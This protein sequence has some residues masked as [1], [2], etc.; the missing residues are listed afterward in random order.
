MLL[1]Y[2]ESCKTAGIPKGK[3]VDNELVKIGRGYFEE[4]VCE[5]ETQD[6]CF[7]KCRDNKTV[8]LISNFAKTAPVA[9]VERFDSKQKK[10]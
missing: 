2:C 7:V 9:T 6:V 10:K 1:W 5:D 8:H 4:L 3:I